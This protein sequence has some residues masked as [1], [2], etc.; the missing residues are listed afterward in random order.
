MVLGHGLALAL[1]GL[2]LGVGA[3]FFLTSLMATQLHDVAP[4][5]LTTFTGVPLLMVLVALVASYIPAWRATRVDPLVALR[6]D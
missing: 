5:D 2:V 3:A 4:R 6:A 1:A